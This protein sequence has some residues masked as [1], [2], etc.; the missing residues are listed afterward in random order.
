M[1]RQIYYI[2]EYDWQTV[3]GF[4]DQD[5]WQFWDF[6]CTNTTINPPTT[7]AL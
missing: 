5:V 7:A 2:N 1:K 4:N 6:I 3:M